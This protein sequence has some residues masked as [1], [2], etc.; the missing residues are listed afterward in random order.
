MYPEAGSNCHAALTAEIDLIHIPCNKPE[1][2]EVL[3]VF[4]TIHKK[5][6]RLIEKKNGCKWVIHAFKE[7][8]IM[9]EAA[10]QCQSVHTAQF[11]IPFTMVVEGDGRECDFLMA[12]EDVKLTEHSCRS[13][14]ASIVIHAIEIQGCFQCKEHNSFSRS[15]HIE[16]DHNERVILCS[17]DH[18]GH[19]G[20]CVENEHHIHH[21]CDCRGH[22]EDERCEQHNEKRHNSLFDQEVPSD[23]HKGNQ[24]W[25]HQ[26][27]KDAKRR[28]KGKRRRSKY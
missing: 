19:N 15:K 16:N 11:S 8:K 13:L 24:V 25:R 10:T 9:Y 1:I 6:I 7:I 27:L 18:D 4:V 5:E 20:M 2:G 26:K 23:R 12:V 14:Y 28:R 3:D 17:K 22:E 21:D